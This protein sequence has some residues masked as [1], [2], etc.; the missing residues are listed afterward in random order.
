MKLAA[1]AA[2][3]FATDVAT[4][5]RCGSISQLLL[6]QLYMPQMWLRLPQMWL[7]LPQMWLQLLLSLREVLLQIPRARLVLAVL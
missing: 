6:S 1:D 2:P 3:N 4:C 7:Q 5:H